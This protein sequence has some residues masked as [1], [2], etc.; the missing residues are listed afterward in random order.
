V[1]EEG[2]DGPAV[3][4]RPARFLSVARSESNRFRCWTGDTAWR[5]ESGL[6]WS[7]RPV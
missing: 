3:N 2:E 5:Q 6:S 1:V 7:T 4:P